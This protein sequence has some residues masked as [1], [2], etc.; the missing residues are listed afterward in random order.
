[1][2]L[3]TCD[4]QKYHHRAILSSV[5]LVLPFSTDRPPIGPSIE[6]V[7]VRRARRYILR[8]RPDGTLRVTVPR[9][10]SCAAGQ[11]FAEK[12]REWVERERARIRAERTSER[13]V[14]GAAILFR[15][16]RAVISAEPGVGGRTLVTYGDRRVAVDAGVLDFRAAIEADLRALA[17][18]ELVARLHE[19]AAP[20]DLAVGRVSIRSQQ[21]RWGSCSRAGAVALNYRLVQ[22]PPAV[23]DYVLL[24]ELMHLKQQ[25]HSRR[26]W[27]LVQNVCPAFR[28][29][30]RW[31]KT[32]G[33][34]LF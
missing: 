3:V 19:L 34:K 6:F 20:H 13:W 30:E 28:D 1:V 16:E 24:H 4:F 2:V 21:S 5:Q 26:F 7:R 11:E 8:V 9:G 25:N 14:P 10:G 23:A 32:E 22:M 29:A 33:R 15:G 31:L 27:R 12:H 17:R 18:V